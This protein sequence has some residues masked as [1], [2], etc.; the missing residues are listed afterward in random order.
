MATDSVVVTER[1]AASREAVYEFFVDPEKMIRWIGTEARL[2]PAP[3]GEFWVNVTGD[4]IA[5]GTYV[6]LDPP[7]SVVFTWGWEGSSDLPPGSSTV[8]ITLTSDGDETLVE[9]VHSGLAGGSE[10]EHASGWRHYVARLVA[11][12]SGRDPGPNRPHS[13]PINESDDIT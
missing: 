7:G 9:L 12:N 13:Q 6:E 2:T 10:D 4:D 8:S 1:I 5:I 3:S 11:I